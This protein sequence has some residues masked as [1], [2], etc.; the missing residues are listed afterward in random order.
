MFKLGFLE[1]S[2]IPPS[3]FN[4]LFVGGPTDM[5]P[6]STWSVLFTLMFPENLQMTSV[7]LVEVLLLSLP[8]SRLSG[9]E[10]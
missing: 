7:F 4:P 8:C 5:E 3:I 10:R 6:L 1:F 2:G 9:V